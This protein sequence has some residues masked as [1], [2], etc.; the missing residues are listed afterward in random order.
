MKREV[1]AEA[2]T[3]LQDGILEARRAGR[4][5]EVKRLKRHRAAL[6]AGEVSA[7]QVI[8]WL[9]REHDH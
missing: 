1:W 2:A 3:R 7:E 6:F 4:R 9:D 5:E 8:E